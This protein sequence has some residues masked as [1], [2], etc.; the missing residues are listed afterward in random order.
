MRSITLTT[1]AVFMVEGIIHYNM[2]K[3]SKTL[4]SKEELFRIAMIVGVFSIING[5]ILKNN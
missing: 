5:M 2:G 4:P 1:F 3:D